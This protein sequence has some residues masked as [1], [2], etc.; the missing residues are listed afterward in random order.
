MKRF[1]E[2]RKKRTTELGK[3]LSFL[4]GTV[5]LKMH[6]GLFQREKSL[7]YFRGVNFHVAVLSN[8]KEILKMIPTIIADGHVTQLESIDDS[9]KLGQEML[10]FRMMIQM[11]KDPG[12]MHSNP[13]I[14]KYVVQCPQD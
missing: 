10:K 8:K 11:R 1:E 5:G 6:K 4:T 9:I 7:E 2:E 14:P 12:M 13:K 3:V